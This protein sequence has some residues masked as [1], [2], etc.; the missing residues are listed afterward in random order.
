[1][2]LRGVAVDNELDF[3]VE[4]EMATAKSSTFS[5]FCRSL[6]PTFLRRPETSGSGSQNSN[7]AVHPSRRDESDRKGSR[8]GKY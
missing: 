8:D 2:A 7:S 1:M 6:P 3:L 4:H 5:R